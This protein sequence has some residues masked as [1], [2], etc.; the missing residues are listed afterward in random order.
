MSR[1]FIATAIAALVFA[2]GA[3]ADAQQSQFGTTAEA[4]AL[5][6][7]AVAAVRADK[8]KALAMFIR[9]DGGFKDRDLYVFCFNAGDGIV[10]AA[11]F[12]TLIGKD[13]R[14]FKD[15]MGKPFGEENYKAAQKDEGQITEVTYRFPRPGAD[16]TPAEKV[17]FITR[18]GD[19]GCGVGYYK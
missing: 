15:A 8:A 11:A 1:A 9:G 7:R 14:T 2:L 18:V 17:S 4:R 5:L 12:T 16:T 10:T 3:S 6:E 19:Q 13:V